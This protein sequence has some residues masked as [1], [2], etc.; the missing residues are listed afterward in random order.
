MVRAR[1][2]LVVAT[3][4]R[5]RGAVGKVDIAGLHLGFALELGI[6]LDDAFH[7]LE[8]TG[9][10]L[11]KVVGEDQDFVGRFL[12]EAPCQRDGA[13]QRGLA[14][15]LDAAVNDCVPWQ[16]AVFVEVE[17]QAQDSR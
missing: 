16:P 17:G 4:R 15:L 6:V 14:A 13:V 1:G 12:S 7:G 2:A 8:H 9:E 3:D 10:G 11:L 5:D